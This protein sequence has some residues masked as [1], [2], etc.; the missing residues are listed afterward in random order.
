M[1]KKVALIIGG[2]GGFGKEAAI[3]FSKSGYRIILADIDRRRALAVEESIGQKDSLSFQVDVRSESSV[4]RLF[5]AVRGHFGRLDL[6]FIGHGVVAGR[7]SVV[8]L[9]Y[10]TWNAVIETN[11]NGTFL[12]LKYSIPLLTRRQS[13]GCII[14]LT[15]TMN[16]TQGTTP[17]LA[18]KSGVDALCKAVALEL[19]SKKI[20]VYLLAPGGA[21]STG[22]FDNSY[23]LLKY[24]N[25]VPGSES[26]KQY[27]TVLKPGVIVPACLQLAKDESLRLTGEK[28]NALEWNE[29]NGYGRDVWYLQ[30]GEDGSILT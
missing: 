20:G 18:S 30:R 17:Y 12:C 21:T 1:T 14:C 24:K 11:L 9:D 13:A 19:K 7:L 16:A 25:Y 29:K 28:I 22:I 23:D 15:T 2:G 27:S 26:L 10:K 4:R 6:L 3:A 8:D 5:N